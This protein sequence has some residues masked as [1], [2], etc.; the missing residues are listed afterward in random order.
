MKD[1]LLF[2]YMVHFGCHGSVNFE[3]N[4]HI[5]KALLGQLWIILHLYKLL[6][7]TFRTGIIIA[8]LSRFT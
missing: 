8:L 4:I 3:P 5:F 6:I 1:K 2:L 7:L